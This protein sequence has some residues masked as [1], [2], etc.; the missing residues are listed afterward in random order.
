MAGDRP[1][2][3]R[4][5]EEER[6]REQQYRCNQRGALPQNRVIHLR[7][8]SIELRRTTSNHPMAG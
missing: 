8:A 6:Q 1:E 2:H 5:P 7:D 4:G 3:H